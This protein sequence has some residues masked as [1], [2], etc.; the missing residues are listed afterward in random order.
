[1]IYAQIPSEEQRLQKIRQC[2]V[3]YVNSV[4]QMRIKRRLER[5]E[6]RLRRLEKGLNEREQ[7]VMARWNSRKQQRM[8]QQNVQLCGTE[9]IN[10]KI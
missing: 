5:M 2:A 9:K 3:N 1:M 10:R 8:L 4:P 7:D 6:R